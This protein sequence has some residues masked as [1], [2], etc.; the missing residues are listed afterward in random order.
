MD[1]S[2]LFLIYYLIVYAKDIGIITLMNDIRDC[3]I[4]QLSRMI[5]W[6]GYISLK[7]YFWDTFLRNERKTKPKTFS[8]PKVGENIAII[9]SK[10]SLQSDIFAAC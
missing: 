4:I 5:L 2:N 1:D 10:L 7:K 6:S 3:Y 9:G 8:S